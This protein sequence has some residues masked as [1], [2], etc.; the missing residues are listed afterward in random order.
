MLKCELS[1]SS[2]LRRAGA[3]LALRFAIAFIIVTVEWPM[4]S[5]AEA[6]LLVVWGRADLYRVSEFK[7]LR[8]L[9][10]EEASC[11]GNLRTIGEAMRPEAAN[12]RTE[13][14]PRCSAR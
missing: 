6:S 9:S 13:L 14:F 10:R 4:E 5:K 8:G 2:W 7:D 1:K 11:V 12:G 3:V